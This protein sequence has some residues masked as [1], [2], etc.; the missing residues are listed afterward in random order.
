MTPDTKTASKRSRP[1]AVVDPTDCT[2]CEICIAVCPV[3]CIA[4]VDS[5][6]SFLGVAVIDR[7]TCT[8][9]NLCAIDC[10][11]EAISMVNPDGSL[12]DYDKQLQKARK[13][14]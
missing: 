7:E 11:W 8:G 9:C 12:F 4:L 1:T 5:D 3:D 14:V 13:Y 6:S 2:G 10:P